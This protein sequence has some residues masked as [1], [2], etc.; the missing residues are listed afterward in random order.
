MDHDVLL[1]EPDVIERM[2]DAIRQFDLPAVAVD[3]KGKTD[4]QCAKMSRKG[5][6]V[7]ALIMLRTDVLKQIHFLPI[8]YKYI[9]KKEYKEYFCGSELYKSMGGK[10]SC[11]CCNVNSHIAYH[12]NTLIP[13]MRGI[14]LKE[15]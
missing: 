13:Y 5:H 15:E 7:I 1:T 4:S 10:N 8:P 2:R 12:Y 3:T 6:T 11:L 14:H 9:D